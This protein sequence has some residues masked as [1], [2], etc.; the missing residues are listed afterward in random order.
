MLPPYVSYAVD[1][2][3]FFVFFC[4]L[5]FKSRSDFTTLG[6]RPLLANRPEFLQASLL[7]KS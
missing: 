1:L 3:R 4:N 5:A 2:K 6:G 7:Y